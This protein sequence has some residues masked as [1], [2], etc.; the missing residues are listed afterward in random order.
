MV[1]AAEKPTSVIRGA[2]GLLYSELVLGRLI[3]TEG[4]S[5]FTGKLGD[6]YDMRLPGRVTARTQTLR[7]TGSA[8]T[9]TVDDLSETSVPIKLDTRVYTAVGLT[10]ENET[11]DIDDFG[12]QVSVPQMK[13]MAKQI[14]TQ[15]ATGMAAATYAESTLTLDTTDVQV[16]L[17]RA[18]KLLDSYDVPEEDRVLVCGL[19]VAETLLNDEYFR[20]Y[21]ATGDAAAVTSNLQRGKLRPSAGFEIFKSKFIS[22]TAA[23]AFH[24]TAYALAMGAPATPRGAIGATAAS[25]GVAARWMMDYAADSNT[26]R[27]IFTTF[28][29]WNTVNDGE[30]TADGKVIRALP[31]TMA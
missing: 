29:G 13:G 28:T 3:T 11:L 6:T 8:R 25:D 30:G 1:Y 21:D 10:D 9:I 27:S 18:A 26:N 20:R 4:L 17:N 24:P 23:Y 7:A 22:T 12:W 5:N 14:E 16:T 2:I 31:I 15:I 19:D